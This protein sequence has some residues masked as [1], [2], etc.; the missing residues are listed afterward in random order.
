[1][2]RL[3]NPEI[4]TALVTLTWIL[5]LKRPPF[6][7]LGHPIAGKDSVL[8]TGGLF[9]LGKSVRE[10]HEKLEGTSGRAA[11]AGGTELHEHHR[12]GA[13]PG[14][15]LL[16]RFSDHRG[17]PYAFCA[18]D[19]GGHPDLRRIMLL[20]SRGIYSFANRHPTVK[21]LALAFLLLIG[22]TLVAEG[23]GVHIPKGYV[24]FAMGF[25]IFVEWLNLRAGLRG[26]PVKLHSP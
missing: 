3:T 20:A 16:H 18:S 19:D 6:A 4:W 24:Y 22:F 25:A 11:R 9:L 15:R 1:M 17:R 13:S 10:I 2:D 7:V 8:I 12:S 14:H 26:E 23:T 21:I 5:A